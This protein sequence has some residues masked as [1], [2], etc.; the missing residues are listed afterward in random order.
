MNRTAAEKKKQR[1]FKLGNQNNERALRRECSSSRLGHVNCK[2]WY[3]VQFS[4]QNPNI[5]P[6]KE[7]LKCAYNKEEEEKK[8]RR[9]N[10]L[11]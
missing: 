10:K 9:N 11:L 2:F 6:T 3:P 8:E 1:T 5:L 7:S 4:R